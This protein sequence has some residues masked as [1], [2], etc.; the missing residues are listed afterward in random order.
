MTILSQVQ[1]DQIREIATKHGAMDVRLFGSMAR[2]TANKNSDIDLLVR[3]GTKATLL[4][5]IGF[6]QAVEEALGKK[7][8][9]VEEGGISPFLAERIL[10]DAIEI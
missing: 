6:Q 5:V 8:D 7:V 9:V 2:N 4:T 3:F 10:R 1:R